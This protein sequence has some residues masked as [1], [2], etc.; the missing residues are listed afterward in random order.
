MVIIV[1][2]FLMSI[3]Y[4]IGRCARD[5]IVDRIERKL[6]DLKREKEV[7]EYDL[8]NANDRISNLETT[9]ER[10]REKYEAIDEVIYEYYAHTGEVS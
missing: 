6:N 3:S 10:T 9:L 5:D 4:A 8:E 1:I 7:L 2:A